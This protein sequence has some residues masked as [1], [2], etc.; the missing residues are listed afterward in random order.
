[1]ALET[2]G[3]TA[4]T[5]SHTDPRT[6]SAEPSA[7]SPRVCAI[8]VTYNRRELL[9]QVLAA[10]HRQTRRPDEILL[11]DNASTDGTPEF[12]AERY[13]EVIVQTQ[14]SN[15]GGA[16]GFAAG[17]EWGHQRGNEWIWCMDDDTVP[18]SDAL[19]ELLEA[20]DRAP[21]KT[22]LVLTSRVLWHDG[23]PHP[24]NRAIPRWRWGV[25]MADGARRGLLLVRSATFVSTMLHRTCVDRFGLPPEHY[26][27]WADDIEYT[28]RILREELGYYVPESVVEHLTKSTRTAQ[29]DT[30]DRYYFHVR[31]Y[32][33]LLRGTAFAPV[34]RLAALR[35]YVSTLRR[36]LQRTRYRPAALSVVFRGVRDGVRGATR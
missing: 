4:L 2:R 1:M 6:P 12:V 16:G 28:S 14:A 25:E 27:L 24:M 18:R 5:R 33:L 17:I 29:D 30:S 35:W 20:L 21:G 31:N 3:R 22:P 36:Y 7:E 13:P 23:T 9:D 11:I 26:F 15:R 34:E 8:V 19:R 10:L 32:L